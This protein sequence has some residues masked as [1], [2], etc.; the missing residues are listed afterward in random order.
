MNIRK[1]RSCGAKRF[2]SILDLGKHPWCGDFLTR[3]E[4]GKEQYF[5]LHLVYCLNCTLLQLNFTVPKE[6]MFSN[7]SYLSS[8]TKTLKNYFYKLA[9]EN[10]KQFNIKKKE[11]ILDIGG[12]DGTQMMQY[13]RAGMPNTINVESASNIAKI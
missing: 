7:H 8:T 10:K 3:R 13:K 5:P 1:C 6:K 11:V 2:K 12:N 4:L 9:L